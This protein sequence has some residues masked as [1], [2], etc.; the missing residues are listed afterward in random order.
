MIRIEDIIFQY[1]HY[2]PDHDSAPLRKAYILGT[3]IYSEKSVSK[4]PLMDLALETASILTDLHLDIQSIIAAILIGTIYR[5]KDYLDEIEGLLGKETAV[6]VSGI[7]KIANLS[8]SSSEEERIAENMKQMM[9]ATLKDVRVIFVKLA[10]RLALARHIK[11]FFPE[12]QLEISKESLEIFAPIAHRLGL[13]QI[14]NELE[15]LCFKVIHPK[16]YEKV[17]SFTLQKAEERQDFITKLHEDL[18]ELLDHNGIEAKI[19]ARTKHHYSIYKKASKMNVDF[20]SIYDLVAS[21]IHVETKADCYKV[22]GLIHENFQPMAGR[23]KDYISMPKSNGYQS[24]HTTVLNKDKL[25]FEV[26]IRTHEMHQFAEMGVAAHWAYK[27]GSV[28]LPQEDDNIRW[29]RELTQTLAN[30]SDPKETLEVFNRELYSNSVYVFSPKGKIIKLPTG[31]SVIDFAYAIH[32][33]IGDH[34]SGAKINGRMVPIR[35]QLQSGDQIEVITSKQQHPST[36][37]LKYAVTNRALSK[38]RHKLREQA[39]LEAEQL[40]KEVLFREAKKIDI[41]SADLEQ[42]PEFVKFMNRAGYGSLREYCTA[43]GFGKEE[44]GAFRKYFLPAEPLGRSIRDKIAKVFQSKSDDPQIRGAEDIPTRLANCCKPLKGEPIVGVNT[45]GQWISIHRPDCVNAMPPKV[46]PNRIMELTWEKELPEQTPVHLEFEY[47][48]D[49]KTSLNILKLMIAHKAT[50]QEN[51]SKVEKNTV[52]QKL[53]IKIPDKGQ[54]DKLLRKAQNM[55]G[56]KVHR[57]S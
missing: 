5:D 55:N 29:M 13:S 6:I 18:K 9:F 42:N 36:D 15:N 1:Q 43:L 56:V 37:W 34:C 7:T 51:H 35:S 3:R 21:R 57:V 30:V 28:G 54:L 2:A 23:F 41:K 44:I 26:Q 39:Q 24:L 47:Q 4:L 38:I 48:N 46:N 11:A 52:F 53:I 25:V 40:G 32:T 27:E 49:L 8:E 22:L 33:E 10:Y 19:E 12:K 16:D 50:L 45:S 31:A 20:S 17:V 14:K